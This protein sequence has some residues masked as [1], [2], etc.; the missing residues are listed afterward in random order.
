MLGGS[1]SSFD[2]VSDVRMRAD[3]AAGPLPIPPSNDERDAYL[4]NQ[5]RWIP[6]VSF[7]GNGLIVTSVSLFVVQ[8]AW[9]AFLLVPLLL[10][11]VGTTVSLITSTRRRR[12]DL[13]DHRIRVQSWQPIGH[14]SVD[15]FL[16]SAG[17]D[18]G[19]LRNTYR[20][21][22]QLRWPG[23]LAVFVLDDSARREVAD[24]AAEFGF[25]YLRRPDRGRLKK[26]GNLRYGFEHSSGDLIA[27]LDAD[28][29]PRA[30]MLLELAPYFDDEKIALVQSPQFFEASDRMNWLQRAAGAT[31]VLFYR[32]VQPAR[33]R[34]DAA[35]CVG[36]SAMYR[37]AALDRAGGFAQIGHSEDVH[38]GVKLIRAGYAVRYVPTVVT[39][40]LCPD[41]FDQFVTQQYRWCA[42]SMSLLFSRDFHRTRL[43]V[44]QRLC[45]FSG[46]LYYITTAVNIFAAALPPILMGYFAPGQVRAS[47]YVFV[48]LAI[49]GRQAIL[50]L[51][52]MKQESLFGLAR[53]QATY[54]F[55]HAVALW[56]SL[57]GHTDIWVATGSRVRS[58]TARRVRRLAT[59][60]IV[61]M[62]IL[63]WTAIVW[64]A[65]QYGPERF[66]PMMVFAAISLYI[67]YPIA[68]G[69]ASV[70]TRLRW[71]RRGAP[72]AREFGRGTA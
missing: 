45:Y 44:M 43:T 18:M 2:F 34:S 46:F 52:T 11:A 21:V 17:E 1:V 42:G 35:I 54:S 7:V 70:P 9:S 6:I 61:A 5:H 56:D 65:P 24:A 67:T 69:S 60:W 37:R 41:T 10:S 20:R 64:R 49:V 57:R 26:A 71:N 15:L 3:Q 12:F 72:I 66:W 27:I 50:P 29:V 23:V 22:S 30:D 38:T 55:A 59:V 28:F 62:Q 8:H 47:N 53:I 13:A 31:Q 25:E 51:I 36:T 48:A 68:L 58:H 16:P 32:W 19:V 14:P 40:G 63:L 4:G 39:K 33:D